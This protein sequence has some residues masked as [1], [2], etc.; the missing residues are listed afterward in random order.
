MII[1]ALTD[2]HGDVSPL[3]GIAD[4]LAA[5]DVVVI[6]GDVT[7]FGRRAEAAR[8]IE[9][10]RKYNSRVLAVP[11]NCDYPEVAALLTEEGINLDCTVRE[12]DGVTFAGIGGSLPCPGTT[13]N[14]MTDDEMNAR[15]ERLGRVLPS[16]RPLVVAAHQPPHGTEAD[17]LASGVHVGSRSLRAFIEKHSPLI[18]FTGHIHEGR[19]IDT[20]VAT[21]TVV[22]TDTVVAT[23]VVNP[24]P[25]G[26][27]HHAVAEISNRVERLEIRG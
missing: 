15:L 17:L 27:G 12:I 18:C 11:G 1:A 23:K 14:E 2:L 6:T 20:V 4:D 19:T 22:A 13:P 9:A 10:V 26:Y 3:R 25:L 21:G 24:G 5:A 8:V 7:H 16:G